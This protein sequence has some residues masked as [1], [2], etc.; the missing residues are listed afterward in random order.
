MKKQTLL[1]LIIFFLA[2]NVK[3]STAQSTV[4]VFSDNVPI[5]YVGVDF[6][7]AR[8]YGNG[9]P[10]DGNVFT[11]LAKRINNL[12]ITE[13]DK[14][15][16]EKAV[17]KEVRL[18][19]DVTDALNETV[20]GNKMLVEKAEEK[21]DLSE[22]KVAQIISNYDLKGYEKNGV[23]MVFVVDLL[24]K[25][26][27]NASMWVTFFSLSTKKVIFTEQ[28]AGEAGGFGLRNY[29]ARPFAEVIGSIKSK[30][31]KKW[32]SKYGAK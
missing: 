26:A 2:I 20:D 19:I 32:K 18:K 4:D 16:I 11:P 6:T 28:L 5:T 30:E 27:V 21:D 1:L 14:Y 22:E 31:W 8:Y 3:K 23:G 7:H 10:F 25:N 17:K 24:D 12:I 9:E 13:Y 15:N 29:W